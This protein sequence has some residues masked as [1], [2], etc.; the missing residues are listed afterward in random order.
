MSKLCRKY[1]AGKFFFGEKKS[2]LCKYNDP[3]LDECTY[4]LKFAKGILNERVSKYF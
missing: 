1:H 2:M 4:H 3:I